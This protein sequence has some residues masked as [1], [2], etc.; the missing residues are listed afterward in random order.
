[1]GHASGRP[2]PAA[3]S[4]PAM[5]GRRIPD[6]RRIYRGLDDLR[7]LGFER[8]RL[9]SR[10][11]HHPDWEQ[12]PTAK[13]AALRALLD[14]DPEGPRTDLARIERDVHRATTR[15]VALARAWDALERHG[16][17]P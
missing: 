4:W 3:V 6:H 16:E 14:T 15:L 10:L 9:W 17:L 12:Q 7:R 13:R 5:S 1:M 8:E 2:T 11:E